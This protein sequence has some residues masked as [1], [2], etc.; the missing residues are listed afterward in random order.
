MLF[1][2]PKIGLE[3][4][5]WKCWSSL[6][7][8]LPCYR[9][10]ILL[11]QMTRP[12]ISEWIQAGSSSCSSGCLS[13]LISGCDQPAL[14]LEPDQG[15]VPVTLLNHTLFLPHLSQ[16][17]HSCLVFQP[18]LWPEYTFWN[19]CEAILQFQMN[20]SMLQVRVQGWPDWME[21]KKRLALIDHPRLYMS[22][23]C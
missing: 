14:F 17:S 6:A 11:P 1:H 20:H 13:N 4:S 5:W 16:T 22:G 8:V 15:Y 3:K 9:Q 2:S 18:V 19:L 23:T 21:W 7:L 10:V 12:P